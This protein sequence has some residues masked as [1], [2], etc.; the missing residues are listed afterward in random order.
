M[1]GVEKNKFYLKQAAERK[2]HQKKNHLSIWRLKS[3]G[4][5]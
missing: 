2:E 3:I 1:L 4:M 5:L